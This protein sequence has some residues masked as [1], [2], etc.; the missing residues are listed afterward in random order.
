MQEFTFAINVD[1]LHS[2]LHAKLLM[3]NCESAKHAKTCFCCIYR[4]LKAQSSRKQVRMMHI[5]KSNN[6]I[7]IKDMCDMSDFSNTKK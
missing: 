2:S 3:Y 6:I 5:Y 7:I 1:C 4:I